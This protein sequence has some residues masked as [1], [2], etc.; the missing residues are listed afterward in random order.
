M[1][2]PLP[3]RVIFYR[4]DNKLACPDF[5]RSLPR[6]ALE[7]SDFRCGSIASVWARSS[8][9]HF[10]RNHNWCVERETRNPVDAASMRHIFRSH[11]AFLFGYAKPVPVNFRALRR[12]RLDAMRQMTTAKR[13][14]GSSTVA[15]LRPSHGR[16]TP[17]NGRAI[18]TPLTSIKRQ[19]ISAL[20]PDLAALY[21]KA[22]PR[23]IVPV[24]GDGGIETRPLPHARIPVRHAGSS[25]LP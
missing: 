17:N 4:A 9:F 5:P 12:P 21:V 15:A 10:G 7:P 25:V 11:R 8:D 13:R 3:L 20:R 2:T 6:L 24:G 1:H 18:P 22:L 23:V 14:F 16:S 19:N